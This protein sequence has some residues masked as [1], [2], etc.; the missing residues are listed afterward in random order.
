[1][2]NSGRSITVK[3]FLDRLFYRHYDTPTPTQAS[4]PTD[5]SYLATGTSGNLALEQEWLRVAQKMFQIFCEKQHDY[6]PQNIGVGGLAGVIIR[7]GDKTSRLF[8]LSG[9]NA[10]KK[11]QAPAVSTESRLDTFLDLA[12]YGIAGVLL[13]KEIWPRTGPEE[14]WSVKR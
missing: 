8:T 9:L 4:E 5:W 13:E 2:Y 3:S 7:I 6:G 12:N 11:D 10:N 14:M 1:M